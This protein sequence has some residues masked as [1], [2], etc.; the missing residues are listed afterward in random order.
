MALPSFP[1]GEAPF[2]CGGFY[3]VSDQCLKY[4]PESDTWVE[5]GTLNGGFGRAFSG[6]GSS[7]HWGL[8]MVGGMGIL[9][10]PSLSSVETTYNGETFASLP[11]VPVQ[12]ERSCVVPIDE[13]RIFTCGGN[14]E[15]TKTFIYEYTNNTWQR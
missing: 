8:V 13:E 3:P 12:N 4:S 6:Y 9:S 14:S 2:I 15:K 10:P 5:S 1:E 11:N 7:E